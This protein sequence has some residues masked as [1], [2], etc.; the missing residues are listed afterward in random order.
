MKNQDFGNLD[1]FAKYGLLKFLSENG[2]PLFVNWYL[3]PDKGTPDAPAYLEQA[4]YWKYDPELYRHLK[5]F[6]LMEG[7]RDVRLLED[8]DLF[9]NARFY[10]M[11][12]DFDVQKT[13]E[14]REEAR[15]AWHS[16]AVMECDGSRLVFLDPDNGI[17]ENAV[18]SVKDVVHFAFASE[19]EDYFEFGSDL[20][21]HCPR[22]RRTDAQWESAKRVMAKRL[23]DAYTFAITA[24]QG[25]QK[26][27]VFVARPEHADQYVTLLDDFLHTGW[28][29]FFALETIV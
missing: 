19:A 14:E 10:R 25:A 4:K 7:L 24:K 26:S 15:E 2:V 23:P 29:D 8:P 5:E 16:A 11:P 1:E 17:R 13:K 20:L 28:G 27:F 6:V 9:P 22:G 12:L 21:Y 18:R 3:S